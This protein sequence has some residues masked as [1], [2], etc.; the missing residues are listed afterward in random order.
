MR[1]QAQPRAGG[2]GVWAVVPVEGR[3]HLVSSALGP[4]FELQCQGQT[5]SGQT[6]EPQD[7]AAQSGTGVPPHPL[8]L[9]TEDGILL[10]PSI[11]APVAGLLSTKL[12]E[13]LVA[14][15]V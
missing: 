5:G 7:G 2:P 3:K 11:P 15:Q 14:L 8:G 1:P 9:S 13:G 6:G 12:G 4:W 10:H